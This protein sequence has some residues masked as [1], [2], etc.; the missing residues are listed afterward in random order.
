M[1]I[2]A[3]VNAQFDDLVRED[4]ETAELLGL[5]PYGARAQVTG[6]GADE[7]IQGL[8]ESDVTIVSAPSG[9]V[10]GARDVAT[11]TRALRD[12]PRPASKFRVAVD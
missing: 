5:P 2:D 4:V 9:H 1:V 8:S 3:L 6:E 12:A 7:F 10:V 11:L